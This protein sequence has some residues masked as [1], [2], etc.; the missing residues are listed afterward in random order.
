[1]EGWVSYFRELSSVLRT[2]ERQY[3]VADANFSEYIVERF[4][5]AIQSSAS[6]SRSLDN[7][8][9][10][11]LAVGEENAIEQCRQAL[12]QLSGHLHFL[13][14]QW[15]EYQALLDSS[16]SVHSYR[17]P[18]VH[19]GSLGRPRFDVSK[20]QLEYLLSLSFSWTE[21]ASLLGVSRMTLYRYTL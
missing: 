11:L 10:E 13:L 2:A 16:L 12:Q 7:V 4:E 6:V 17:T 14:H 19:A 8:Q 15:R 3:G 5:L 21:I 20:E 1:M 18:L 9:V